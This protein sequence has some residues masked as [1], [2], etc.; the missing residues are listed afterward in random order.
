MTSVER[1]LHGLGGIY[2]GS[3]RVV[4]QSTQKEMGTVTGK[5]GLAVW[6]HPRSF[7]GPHVVIPAPGAPRLEALLLLVSV[8][9]GFLW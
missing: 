7:P 8:P 5:T 3:L 4:E 6:G 9:Q 1:N 2:F